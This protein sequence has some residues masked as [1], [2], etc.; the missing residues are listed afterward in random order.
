MRAPWKQVPPR[1]ARASATVPFDDIMD[2]LRMLDRQ[3]AERRKPLP[4]YRRVLDRRGVS[5]RGRSFR[6]NGGESGESGDQ[7][8][9][10]H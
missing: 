3:A 2:A 10:L 9:R 8:S 7:G 5:A 6:T 1:A 4:H